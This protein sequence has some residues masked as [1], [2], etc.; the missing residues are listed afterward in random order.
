MVA[1]NPL[2]LPRGRH[3]DGVSVRV[4]GCLCLCYRR[5]V[6]GRRH[7]SAQTPERGVAVR[8]VPSRKSHVLA[9]PFVAK[10]SAT[11]VRTDRKRANS[12]EIG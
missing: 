3:G 10:L 11:S 7:E 1:L 6:Y 12:V 5:Q 9:H 8:V 2:E 4:G